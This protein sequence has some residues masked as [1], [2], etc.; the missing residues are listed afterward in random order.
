MKWYYFLIAYAVT[1]AVATGDQEVVLLR[2][3]LLLPAWDYSE[4]LV[5][6]RAGAAE[7]LYRRRL[8]S[9][10]AIHTLQIL[11]SENKCFHRKFELKMQPANTSMCVHIVCLRQMPHRILG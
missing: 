9:L 1:S 2:R 8:V 10:L 7:E 5:F 11:T 3:L 6:V 4:F